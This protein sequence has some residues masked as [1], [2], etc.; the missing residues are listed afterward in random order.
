MTC[1][2]TK[3]AAITRSVLGPFSQEKVVSD[4]K[5]VDYFAVSSDASNVGN[6]KTFPY[7]VQYFNEKHGI[8]RKLLD[9]YEDSEETSLDIFQCLQKITAA[10]DLKMSQ[11]SA[12]SADNASVNYGKFNSVYQKLKAKNEHVFRANCNCHVVNNCVKFAIK[13]LDVDIESIVLKMYSEFS[14]SA[15][16]TKK[17]KDCF[18]F[19]QIEY[20]E[21]LR[22]ISTR[23]LSLMPAID[24]LVYSWPA[25][26]HYFLSKGPENCH[27]V[28]WEFISENYDPDVDLNDENECK[29]EGLNE[30]Y[31]YFLQNLLPEFSKVILQLESDSC[32]ILEIDHVMQH[33]LSQLRSR[34]DD[35][36]FGSKVR[37]I[38]KNLSEEQICT[39]KSQA[40]KFLRRS[41]TYLEER[42]DFSSQSTYKKFSLL[43]LKSEKLLLTWDLLSEFPAFLKIEG[44]VD[45]DSLYSEFACLK[46]VF[47]TLPKD[48][49]NDKIWAYLFKKDDQNFINL[50]KIIS[51]VL[52]I[53]VSNAFCER[54]FSLLNN[55][56]TKERNRMSFDLVKAEL[57]TRIN[58]EESCTEFSSFL[59]GPEGNR[60]IK[61]AKSN[62]KYKW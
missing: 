10:C 31:L 28:L 55:L 4:L 58:Y 21:L 23:W 56:W 35:N 16:K 48:M 15:L 9:F 7:A 49:P 37:S 34:L 26:K 20:K 41:I 18:E 14:S 30:C 8:C 42:Y 5:R 60:L 39:F 12:Y 40:H 33:L 51:F 22:H 29:K 19:A 50:R 17:L 47:E 32:T 3:S 62:Q 11:I 45:F 27:R 54:I 59:N 2:R 53:P 61:L 24:R 44:A 6:I 13:G 36:F 52:S 57:Q 43:S 25:V 38:L 1:G 46:A